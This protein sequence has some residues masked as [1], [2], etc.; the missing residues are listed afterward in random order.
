MAVK[1]FDVVIVHEADGGEWVE[2]LTRGLERANLLAVAVPSSD[3][4]RAV[5]DSTITEARVFVIAVGQSLGT[6]IDAAKAIHQKSGRSRG[7]IV[8]VQLP[9][10]E[11]GSATILREQTGSDVFDLRTEETF[12]KDIDRL[13]ATLR[14]RISRPGGKETVTPRKPETEAERM[15]LAAQRTVGPTR[16]ILVQAWELAM[17]AEQSRVHVPYLFRALYDNDTASRDAMTRAAEPPDRFLETI[18]ERSRRAEGTAPAEPITGLPPLSG[19]VRDG[20]VAAA[21]VADDDGSDPIQP[22][23]LLLGMLRITACSMV[24]ALESDGITEA[25]VRAALSEEPPGPDGGASETAAALSPDYV[26]GYANDAVAGEDLLGISN[27]VEALSTLLASRALEPPLALGLFGNW[28]SGKTFFMTKL[29]DRIRSKALFE[30]QK[31]EP[32]TKTSYCESI[33]QINFNA[34]HYIDKELWASL[35]SAIFEG[36]D[37]AVT[38]K[39]LPAAELETRTQK[40]LRLL[41]EQDAN[42]RSLD[43]AKA[44]HAEAQA[45]VDAASARLVALDSADDELARSVGVGEIVAGVYRVATAV[46]EIGARADAIV[47][48]VDKNIINVAEKLNV[49]AAD[50]RAEL[51]A[52]PRGRLRVG[53]A[54]VLRR[55]T[56]RL[57]LLIAGISLIVVGVGLWAVGQPYFGVLAAVIAPVTTAVG[58]A[59]AVAAPAVRIL[60]D[61]RQ[62]TRELIE[63]KRNDAK[64]DV[65]G[66]RNSAQQIADDVKK[67]VEVR[68]NRDA[69]LERQLE[70]TEPGQAMAKFIKMRRASNAYT[71][72]LGVVAQARDDFEQL[73]AYLAAETSEG[74]VIDQ[75][76]RARL[77]PPVDR[78]VLYIDDLDRCTE[79]Q[80]VDVLQAVH[81]LLAFKLFVVVVAV[82]PRWLLHSLRVQ[83]RALDQR[84]DGELATASQSA[85][86]SELGAEW[87]ATPMDYLEK[88]FQLPF[89]LW[90]MDSFGFGRIIT[91]LSNDGP[92]EA[93][94]GAVG[95]G[96]GTNVAHG[97]GD[98]GTGSTPSGDERSVEHPAVPDDGGE[99]EVAVGREV[100]IEIA[101]THEVDPEVLRISAAE[102]EF[103]KLMHSLIATPRSAKR[104]VNVYRLLKASKARERS[105]NF[106]NERVHRPVLLL[107]AL[108]TGFPDLAALILEALYSAQATG[109]PI[110]DIVKSAKEKDLRTREG[111]HRAAEQWSELEDRLGQ[112]LDLIAKADANRAPPPPALNGQLLGEWALPAARYSFEASR[113]LLQYRALGSASIGSA[114]A[115]DVAGA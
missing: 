14:A 11:P 53:W 42:R 115:A 83:S 18:R 15:A 34:W 108:T 47:Q 78:I 112:V 111:D 32:R 31:P 95:G 62:Q 100:H 7:G 3:V 97:P 64:A 101:P 57:F 19:H 74:P 4:D 17:D 59:W 41:A 113:V 92:I 35:A 43:D 90:P 40:R 65:K 24:Q 26:A 48:Q 55:R 88:I 54:S 23:H 69:E 20:L 21:G 28:G 63:G 22:I 8:P 77:V 33:V 81:L 58:A 71:S 80:V 44:V 91:D 75:T 6:V 84:Q 50:L 51:A 72:R 29:Q 39:D 25:R 102:R 9:H 13:A 94:A 61:A 37:E 110:L 67:E 93:V 27:E 105:I 82:D 85:D 66:R 30:R 70:E 106:E 2:R 5:A 45:A 109:T 99:I 38:T 60:T 87:E 103:M 107:L 56:T 68:L 79:R 89:A 96:N 98:G 104:F 52:G 12:D 36:L 73:T 86:E 16:A 1:P 49:P 114:G 76:T 46:P 10:A